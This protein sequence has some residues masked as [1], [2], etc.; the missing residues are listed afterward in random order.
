MAGAAS[1]QGQG[2]TAVSSGFLRTK[3]SLKGSQS[4]LSL[5]SPFYGMKPELPPHSKLVGSNDLITMFDLSAAY[6]RYCGLGP[7]KV[8]DELST[9]LPQVCGTTH[10]NAK[11]EPNIC[12]KQLIEKPP[13]TGKEIGISQSAMVGFKL[14]P[15]P[16]SENMRL[17]DLS[18]GPP[19]K[20]SANGYQEFLQN[21]NDPEEVKA[22]HRKRFKRSLDEMDDGERKTKRHKGEEKEKK[23][24]KKKKEKKKKRDEDSKRSHRVDTS[25]ISTPFF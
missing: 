17:F 15:G 3:I 14:A 18:E 20:E 5:V 6:N 12:L 23:P 13:I 2:S 21:I 24:K 22:K 4:Q 19:E 9:F 25:N 10:I 16:V 8:R 1:E 7:R 11:S